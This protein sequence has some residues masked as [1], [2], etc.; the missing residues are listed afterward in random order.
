MRLS[1]TF[2]LSNLSHLLERP[3]IFSF[4]AV[5]LGVGVTILTAP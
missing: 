4:L 3:V 5:L 1:L 2:T